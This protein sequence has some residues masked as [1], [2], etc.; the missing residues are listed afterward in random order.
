MPADLNVTLLDRRHRGRRGLRV[1]GGR[2]AAADAGV[3]G[4]RGVAAGGGRVRPAGR[5]P[6]SWPRRPRP[7]RSSGR[8]SSPRAEPDWTGCG[9]VRGGCR[10]DVARPACWS[11]SPTCAATRPGRPAPSWW[12]RPTRRGGAS[13]AATSRRSRSSGPRELICRP[14][15][16]PS[17]HVALSD[18]APVEHG[19][20]CC[21]GEV[22]LLLEPMPVRAG[23]RGV[24]HGA[25]RAR[26]R[27]DADPPRA[28]GAPGRLP[29]RPARPTSG[30]RRCSPTPAARSTCTRSRCCPSW[31]SP[32]CPPARTCS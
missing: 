32:S 14:R 11:P 4:A 29:G 2:R 28:G 9:A 20:Q 12:S 16:S 15:R 22:T 27:P 5:Q 3:L 1:Q 8:S 17:W 10:D 21:G 13:A 19:V 6:S 31:S 26:D 23:G 18:K 25:R 30:W 24:R 7:R